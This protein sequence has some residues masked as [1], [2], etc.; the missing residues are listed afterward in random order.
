MSVSIAVRI[1]C[2]GSKLELKFQEDVDAWSVDEIQRQ[3]LLALF[4]LPPVFY[5]EKLQ[6]AQF[7]RSTQHHLAGANSRDSNQMDLDAKFTLCI[8]PWSFGRLLL[9]WKH[10]YSSCWNRHTRSLKHT[11]SAPS[12]RF[13]VPTSQTRKFRATFGVPCPFLPRV[14]RGPDGSPLETSLPAF[15]V[16]FGCHC[17]SAPRCVECFSCTGPHAKHFLHLIPFN[18]HSNPTRK[19]IIIRILQ[20]EK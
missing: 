6:R 19:V 18:P 14:Q 10:G 15:S 11:L 1:L 12:P 7:F 4:P 5:Y 16:P 2:M 17:P 9:S 20:M 13:H 8:S 3:F